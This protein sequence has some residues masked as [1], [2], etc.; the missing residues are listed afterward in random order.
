[1]GR[2]PAKT[3]TEEKEKTPTKQRKSVRITKA[4]KEKQTKAKRVIDKEAK[5]AAKKLKQSQLPVKASGSPNQELSDLSKGETG[6]IT[7]GDSVGKDKRSN[8]L[9]SAEG[10]NDQKLQDLDQV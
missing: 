1:M 7:S 10:S 6:G 4:A 5:E 2:K 3:V 9:G 8:E